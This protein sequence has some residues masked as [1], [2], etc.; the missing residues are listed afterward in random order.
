MELP[1]QARTFS[2]DPPPMCCG[3]GCRDGVLLK[4][5]DLVLWFGGDEG[6]WLLRARPDDWERVCSTDDLPVGHIITLTGGDHRGQAFE[7]VKRAE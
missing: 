4:D 6:D 2:C 5:G 1:T 3:L 7:I